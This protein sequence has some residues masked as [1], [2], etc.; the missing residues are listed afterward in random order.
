VPAG[1][2]SLGAAVTPPTEIKTPPRSLACPRSATDNEPVAGG[3]F[4]ETFMA[5]A[6]L[7]EQEIAAG[8]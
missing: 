2:R 4:Q 5:M 3:G 8:L 7:S 1:T 6:K